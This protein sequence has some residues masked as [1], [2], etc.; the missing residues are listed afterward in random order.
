MAAAGRRAHD[1][2]VEAGA[3]QRIFSLDTFFPA[4][5]GLV[6]VL[7]WSR[8]ELFPDPVYPSALFA[9]LGLLAWLL[10]RAAAAAPRLALPLAVAGGG[11]MLLAIYCA[12]AEVLPWSLPGGREDWLRSADRAFFRYDWQSWWG[13]LAHPGLSDALALVYTGFYLC[14]LVLGWSLARRRDWDGLYGC[15]DRVLLAFLLSY[16]GYLLVPARSPYEI[17]RFAA[18][19]PDG[20]LSPFL[21]RHTIG[22]T[23]TRHDCFPSGH[24]LITCYVAWLSWKRARAVFA[25]LALW[26]ALTLLATLYLR[27]H[28]L[29]DVLAGVA[30]AAV[31]IP[32]FE[33]LFRAAGAGAAPL[34]YAAEERR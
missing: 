15:L 6:L 10:A 2:R 8:P 16:C 33:R 31:V 25:P 4:F 21:F 34:P 22:L 3:A 28:Y 12:L 20:V 18:A 24:V 30:A 19:F 9:L 29:V 32:L 7:I 17:Q 27:Y 26:A 23:G 11:A 5:C 1:T 13:G 14:P